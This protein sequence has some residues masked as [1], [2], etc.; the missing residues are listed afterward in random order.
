LPP[1]PKKRKKEK[2]IYFL[3]GHYLIKTDKEV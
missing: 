2:K 3:K 1:H